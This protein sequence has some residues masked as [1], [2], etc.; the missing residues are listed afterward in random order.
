L[1]EFAATEDED[2]EDE[3]NQL[4]AEIEG[5]SLP[6]LNNVKIHEE[7]KKTENKTTN[8]KVDTKKM[9]EKDLEDFLAA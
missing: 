3:L 5:D 4:A 7:T 9:Q 8:V 2:V 1:T 6:N